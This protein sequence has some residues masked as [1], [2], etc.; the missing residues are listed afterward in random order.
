M[1]DLTGAEA[2]VLDAIDE[3][4]IVDRPPRLVAVPS[5]GG[6]AA[7]SEAQ[8]LLAGWLE[9]LDCVVDRCPIDLP[10]AA[11]APDAPGQEVVGPRHGASSARRRP[12]RTAYRRWSSA[13][14]PTSSRPAT[15]RC[16]RATRSC[17]GWPTARCTA[18][19]PAT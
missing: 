16:G 11:W 2:R 10:E 8:Q 3:D 18:A 7:E 6:T 9:E 13:G 15:C 14:T 19:A 12:P 4:W 1:P 17:R 5:I